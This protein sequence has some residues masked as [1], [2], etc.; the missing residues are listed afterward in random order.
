MAQSETATASSVSL[1]PRSLYE[2]CHHHALILVRSE[3]QG[4][5]VRYRERCPVC[6]KG[7]PAGASGWGAE[8]AAKRFGFAKVK[9]AVAEDDL[10]HLE[11]WER[12]SKALKWAWRVQYETHLASDKWQQIRAVK[13]ATVGGTCERCGAPA[14]HIHHLSYERLGDEPQEDLEAL[15]RPCHW[16]AH[17]RVF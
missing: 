17:G 11:T 13:L 16:Q 3:I 9:L 6:L 1:P 2:W 15:C 12:L 5:G 7:F 4:G 8:K 10:E 14:E